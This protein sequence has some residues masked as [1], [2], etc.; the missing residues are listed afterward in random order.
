[1]SDKEKQNE[2]AVPF[3]A[4]FLEGQHVAEMS[5]EESEAIGGGMEGED[6]D[7]IMTLKYPSDDEDGGVMTRKFP[8][9]NED[10]GGRP[11]TEKFPSDAEDNPGFRRRQR[12][13]RWLRR[14]RGDGQ[15][16]DE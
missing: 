10:G 11:V 13:R 5:E 7:E 9:D 16:D 4:R 2:K 6:P 14:R 15:N 8:S 1:M 12:I 3:F